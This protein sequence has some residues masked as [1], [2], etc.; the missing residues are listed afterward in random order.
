MTR[1]R[2]HYCWKL[3]KIE[4]G[5]KGNET[6]IE[7]IP[8]SIYWIEPDSNDNTKINASYTDITDAI[9]A[10]K[11]PIIKA[12]MSGTTITEIWSIGGFSEDNGQYMVG[13]ASGPNTITVIGYTANEHMTIS[14]G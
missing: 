4:N 10:G 6:S 7:N 9:N 8:S 5:I 12:P 14:Q 1:W 11:F 2:C 3:N 13:F